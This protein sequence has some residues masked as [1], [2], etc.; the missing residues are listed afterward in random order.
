VHSLIEK[1]LTGLQ[2]VLPQ[3][4]MTAAVY[5]LMRCETPWVKNALITV[6]A[7]AAGVDWAEA[8][9]MELD[10][11][12]SFNAFFTRT[13]RDG[14][15]PLDADPRS[16]V[17]PCDGRISEF[18]PIQ[19]QQLLQAK[20]Q[21]YSLADLLADDPACADLQ[22]GQFWT[23]YLSPRDYHRVHMPVAG[24]LRRMTYV[25]G[26]LFSVA[27]YTVRQVPG[28]FARN[29][30]VVSIYETEFGP[31][32]VVLVGAMLVASMDTVWAGTI[33]PTQQRVL[34][35]HDY[36]PGEVVLERGAEMGRFN[37]GSTVVFAIPRGAAQAITE[38]QPGAVLRMGQSL[39]RL[40]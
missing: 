28:L 8:S 10:D 1:S 13:L 27:P 18:G 29:E 4:A 33:T 6:I 2:G 24:T 15:R 40:A 25:P 34:A 39:A 16:L 17:S 7:S 32:A 22:D 37:M 19:G 36:A 9:S 38:L 3:R 30:R 21:F 20:G 23:I 14:A 11:Y 31:L 26:E 35:R 12:A 5:R